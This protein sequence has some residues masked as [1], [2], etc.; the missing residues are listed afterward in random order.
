MH[1][2]FYSP[3]MKRKTIFILLTIFPLTF[4]G[5]L[6]KTNIRPSFSLYRDYRTLMPNYSDNINLSNLGSQMQT[7]YPDYVFNNRVDISDSLPDSGIKSIF[8]NNGILTLGYHFNSTISVEGITLSF[9]DTLGNLN[10]KKIYDYPP[11]N[12]FQGSDII[13]INNSCFYVVGA[14]YKD[15]INWWDP[16][17]AKFN[18][19]GDSIF[20]RFFPDTANSFFEDIEYFAPDTFL[21]LGGCHIN[22]EDPYNK[23]IIDKIDTLGNILYNYSGPSALKKESQILK[24]NNNRIY[25]GGTRRTSASGTFNVKIFINVYDYDLN[26]ITTWNPSLTLNEYFTQLTYIND[27]L[28]VTSIVTVYVPPNP[29]SLYQCR[30]GKVNIAGSGNYSIHNTFGPACFDVYPSNTCTINNNCMVVPI[31][32][33]PSDVYNELFFIDTNLNVLCNAEILY[34]STLLDKPNFNYITV[35]QNKKITGTGYFYAQNINESQDHW[36][37]LTENIET[38]ISENCTGNSIYENKE[39]YMKSF[40]V[41]PN[42]IYSQ[43]TIHT[44]YDLNNATL[45]VTNIFGQTVKQLKNISGQSATLYRDN[46]PNG[47]YFVLLIQ[48][49]KII[50]TKKIVI[51]DWIY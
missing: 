32:S 27:Q 48:D 7:I 15:T 17:F 14:V 45:T 50:A 30:V 24:A 23:I 34:D 37:F 41:D 36:N 43:T 35:S 21:V 3:I 18:S 42:P 26:L 46:L 28:Y 2:N 39:N 20:F 6:D 44:D 5:Q 25:V 19:N 4:F 49:N 31:V 10:W 16:F 9:Y 33:F 22:Y 13:A 38:F 29:S 1:N 8:W 40:S 11:Y 12:Y 47:I 51:Y